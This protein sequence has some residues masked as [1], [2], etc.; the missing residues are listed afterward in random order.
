MDSLCCG[1]S[2]GVAVQ[3]VDIIVLAPVLSCIHAESHREQLP[4]Q[5][6]CNNNSKSPIREN[7][8]CQ[9]LTS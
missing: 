1:N 3:I 8:T 4:I 2:H 7:L 9:F 5:D 6:L